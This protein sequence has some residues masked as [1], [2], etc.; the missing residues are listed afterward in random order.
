MAERCGEGM[1]SK[2]TLDATLPSCPND[3]FCHQA[4]TLLGA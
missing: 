4:A 3:H 2:P 1:N